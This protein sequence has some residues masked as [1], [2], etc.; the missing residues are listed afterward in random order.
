MSIE[1]RIA[2][3]TAALDRNSRAIERWFSAFESANAALDAS[4]TASTADDKK[5]VDKP[6]AQPAEQQQQQPEAVAQQGEPTAAPLTH[7][8]VSAM[9]NKAIQKDRANGPK[10]KAVLSEFG[11]KLI[12]DLPDDKLQVVAD[13]LA[14]LV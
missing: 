11:A 13:K 3:L 4:T 1:D 6:K 5:K 7:A 9:C 10:I 14:A 12:A 8:D 2:E